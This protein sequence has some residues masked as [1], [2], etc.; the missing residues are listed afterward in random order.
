M[1]PA[2]LDVPSRRQSQDC[3]DNY[4]LAW[5][6][7]IPKSSTFSLGAVYMKSLPAY[8]GGSATTY[9]EHVMTHSGV[10]SLAKVNK[11]I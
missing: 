10:Y 4:L 5:I 2:L 8:D 9:M 6:R 7:L 3:R 11:L 1:L